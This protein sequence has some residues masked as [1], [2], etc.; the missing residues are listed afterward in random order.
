M[1]ARILALGAL[2]MLAANVAHAAVYFDTITG[3]TYTGSDGPTADGVPVMAELFYTPGLPNFSQISLTLSAGT[4]TDGGS[5]MVFL[6][7][8]NGPS[9]SNGVASIP[10]YSGGTS[11]TGYNH[12]ALLGTFSDGY[13]AGSGSGTSL[14][15]LNVSAATEAAVAANTNNGEYWVALVPSANSSVEWYYNASS[16]GLDTISQNYF[17]SVSGPGNSLGAAADATGPYQMLVDT[18]EPG[19][20]A[21]LGSGLAAIGYFRRRDTKSGRV[22]SMLRR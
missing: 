10:Q 13:L 4:P 1:N 16:S 3:A 19:T 8:D 5:F 22:G 2:T 9:G 7:P 15:T 6:V 12:A 20:L 18:P 17:N 21:I 14:V 11:F